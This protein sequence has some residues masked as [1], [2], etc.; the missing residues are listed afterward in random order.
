MA[1]LIELLVIV[2]AGIAM[3]LPEFVSRAVDRVDAEA[4]GLPASCGLTGAEV[5]R[6][7]LNAG[8]ASD[9]TLA[10][11]RP[12]DDHFDPDAREVRLSAQV[13]GGRSLL[14]MA[15][16]AH[17]AGHAIQHA[18]GD[19]VYVANRQVCAL[20]R[21]TRAPAS[22]ALAL[23]IGRPFVWGASLLVGRLAWFSRLHVEQ[24][25]TDRAVAL[26]RAHGLLERADEERAVRDV[27]RGGWATYAAH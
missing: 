17:E 27:L 24:D 14:A 3:F 4:A 19:R 5:A 9:V 21:T 25:A 12:G 10:R 18:T 13:Y 20:A 23:G 1:S 22:L 7:L 26:L 11:S 15:V 8:G 6:K 16:A 2:L